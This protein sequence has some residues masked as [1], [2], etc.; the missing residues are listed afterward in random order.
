[1]QRIV[2]IKT[3]KPAIFG[4][5]R[6]IIFM[7]VVSFLND[8]TSD[9]VSSL[10]PIFLT[11]VL[12]APLAFVGVIEGVADSAANVMKI[13]SGR[14]SDKIRKRKIFAVIGYSLSAI[15]KPLLAFAQ[16]PWHVLAVRLFDRAGKGVRE[17]PRD[18]LI[19]FSISKD[20]YARAF[21][22]H[23][24]MDTAGA[25]LGPLVAF[26]LLPILNN[27]LRWLFLLS[28]IASFF[29]VFVLVLFVREVQ[30]PPDLA[31]G[32]TFH[33]FHLRSLG[34]PFYM[35]TLGATIFALGKASEAFLILR[36]TNVGIAITLIPILFFAYNM[37]ATVLS[38]PMGILADKIGKRWTLIGGYAIFAFIYFIF[39]NT[40]TSNAVWALFIAYG[41]YYAATDGVGRAIVAD[42]VPAEFR[43]T[44]YGVFHAI[45]G[46]ALLPGS[47]VFGYL[48]QNFGYASAFQYGTALAIIAV[49]VLSS[50]RI[51]ARNHYRRQNSA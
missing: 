17:A 40:S 47:V 18:A 43:G 15:T 24:A 12:G 45:T 51:W 6:N 49:L 44:A 3:E 5:P 48:S 2:D 21:G 46:L 8:L 4:L 32:N 36:A 11:T 13:V 31:D 41:L 28:F 38:S 1:M 25:A 9:M 37:S 20:R 7:G 39:A 33:A 35:F 42:L 27:N 26:I 50:E 16:V 30:A 23:R 34:L 14:I 22:F 10:I 19:S 29:A